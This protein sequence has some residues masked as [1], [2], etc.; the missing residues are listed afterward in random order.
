MSKGD[1]EQIVA[2]VRQA[3]RS[4][5]DHA[6]DVFTQRAEAA[7]REIT[8]LVTQYTNRFLRWLRIL[9][10]VALV[11]VI[12]WVTFQAI[13]Q[14]SFFDWLGDRIDNLTDE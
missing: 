13:A 11:L 3:A 2:Q 7:A 12:A 1:A 5:I 10:G 14:V 4:E 9:L 6:A 8:P